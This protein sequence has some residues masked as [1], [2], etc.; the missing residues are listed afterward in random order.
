MFASRTLIAAALFTAGLAVP[1][2]ADDCSDN[3]AKVEEATAT[4]QLTEQDMKSV[5][6]FVE[7]AR[8]KQAAGD[9]EGCATTL[10]E[11]KTVLQIQ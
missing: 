8:A 4:A 11:A 1:A 6:G 7:D 5:Q 10:A 2:Y 3:M 9:V